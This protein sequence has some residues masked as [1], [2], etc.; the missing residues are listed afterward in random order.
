MSWHVRESL[1]GRARTSKGV[2]GEVGVAA[3]VHRPGDPA[4]ASVD[5]VGEGVAEPKPKEIYG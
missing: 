5:D 1:P 3:C 4:I 2:K